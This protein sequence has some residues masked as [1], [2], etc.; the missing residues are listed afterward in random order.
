MDNTAY[1]ERSGCK[2][3]MDAGAVDALEERRVVQVRDELSEDSMGAPGN[4]ELDIS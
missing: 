1:A 2:A 3:K 4:D